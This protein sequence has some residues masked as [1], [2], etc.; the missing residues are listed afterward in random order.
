[1]EKMIEE[2]DRKGKI[3]KELKTHDGNKAGKNEKEEAKEERKEGKKE[4]RK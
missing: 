2:K 1:M 4:G 3:W